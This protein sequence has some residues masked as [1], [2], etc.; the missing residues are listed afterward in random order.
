M[1]F[2]ESG[3][4]AAIVCN[5]G[6]LTRGCSLGPP[7]SVALCMC[8]DFFLHFVHSTFLGVS[9]IL[10]QHFVLLYNKKILLSQNNCILIIDA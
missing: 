9:T 10:R 3:Q 4:V 1:V 2:V 7:S 6:S 8:A 5:I